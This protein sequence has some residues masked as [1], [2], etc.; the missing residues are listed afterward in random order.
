MG[1]SW[2]ETSF[3][4]SEADARSLAKHVDS[5]DLDDEIFGGL[6][7]KPDGN[8]SL[9]K[10]MQQS[11]GKG[12]FDDEDTKSSI[13]TAT[14]L[15]PKTNFKK[16]VQQSIPKSS[17]KPTSNDDDDLLADLLGDSDYSE[18]SQQKTNQVPLKSN[19]Q[20]KTFPKRFDNT[21]NIQATSGP[22]GKPKERK[23]VLFDAN[24]G[25]DLLGMIDSKKNT[26]GSNDAN[27]RN[28]TPPRNEKK[29]S[30]PSFG[31]M[32]NRTSLL[33]SNEEPIQKVNTP[34][35][36]DFVNSAGFSPR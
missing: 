2:D 3:D 30:K 17:G 22:N 29:T 32:I 15:T 24:D 21:K 10:A 27:I 19:E 18:A 6:A 9:L 35:N 26:R 12:I 20:I 4:V 14:V 13:K 33:K 16:T 8:K 28:Q 11:T 34:S 7:K 25:S 23:D 36:N 31:D 1:D 5:E